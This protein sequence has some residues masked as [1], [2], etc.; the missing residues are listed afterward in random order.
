MDSSAPSGDQE[1][2]LERRI[3]YIGSQLASSVLAKPAPT[4]NQTVSEA[5]KRT[6][7]AGDVPVLWD[8]GALCLDLRGIDTPPKPLVAVVELIERADT[9]NTVRV[10]IARD[11]VNLYP[12]L[13]ER[14]WSWSTERAEDGSLRLTLTRDAPASPGSRR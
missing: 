12:E 1:G 10:L 2:A 13:V 4:G 3:E 6:P 11:P 8:A 14:G 9:G 7:V 5:V